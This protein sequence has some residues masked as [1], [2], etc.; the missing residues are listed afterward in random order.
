[1]C[2]VSLGSLEIEQVQ[3]KREGVEVSLLATRLPTRLCSNGTASSQ[4]SLFKNLE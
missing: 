2:E 3:Q 4:R 1:M